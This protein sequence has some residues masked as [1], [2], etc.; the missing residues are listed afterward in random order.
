[1][2]FCILANNFCF[3][4]IT[5]NNSNVAA[6]LAN[7]LVGSGVT[8]S[9]ISLTCNTDGAGIFVSTNAMLGIDSGIVL[10]T[11][12]AKDSS[13]TVGVNNPATSFANEN[14]INNYTDSDLGANA[15]DICKLEFDFIP[16]GDSIKFQYK[17]GSE[18]YPDYV[19]S[20][21]N[22]IFGFYISGPG[23]AFP[24][25]LALVPGT[26]IPVTIN[27]INSGVSGIFGIFSNC[28]NM[29]AGSPFSAYYTNNITNTS[30]VYDGLTTLLESSALVTPCTTYHMKFVIA[31]IFD[32][33]YDSGVFLKAGSFK[34]EAVFFDS[35]YT[36][37]GLPVGWPYAT[38]GCNSDTIYIKRANV[39][40]NPQNVYVFTSGTATSGVDFIPIPSIVV[41]PANDSI[42]KIVVTPI[43]DFILDNNETLNIFI[44]SSGCAGGFSDTFNLVINE[45]PIITVS[46]S[47]T[48]CLGTNFTLSA[49]TA[50]LDTSM[51]F[52]WN[53]GNINQNSAIVSPLVNSSY[54]VTASYP[55][56][57]IFDSVV[58]IAVKPSDTATF[59]PILPICNGS[60]ISPLPTI[61][62]NGINGLWSPAINNISTT[63]YTFTP[64]S[65]ECAGTT[66]LTIIIKPNSTLT[67]SA[68][69][70]SNNLPYMWNGQSLTTSGTYTNTQLAANGCDSITTLNF[71]VKPTSTATVT[72]NA[73]SNTL[74]FVWNGQNLNFSG[75]Y[76]N[77]QLGS[78]GCDSIT[79]LNFIVKP[80]ST[81]TVTANACSNNLPFVWNGQNLNASGSFIHTQ[82]GSN[83]CDSTTTL[84]FIVKPTTTN[85]VTASACINNLPYLWN[86]QNLNTSGTFTNTQL[87]S[88]GCDSTT[89]MNF[90]VKPIATNTISIAVCTGDLPYS[91]NGQ[92]LNTAGTYTNTQLAVNGCDSI[93]TLNF[94][95]ITMTF[96]NIAANTCINNLP[97]LWNGQNINSSGIYTD[98]AASSNG[99]DS[100]TI[101]NFTVKPLLSATV[102]ASACSNNLPFVW[103]G[104]NLNTSGSYTNTQVGSNGCDSTTTLNFIVKPTTT[105]TITASACINNLPYVWNGQ[106]LN[107][108]GSYTN[109]QL[110]SNGCDSTTTLNFIVK[111]TTTAT[112]SATACSNNLPYAWNGQ[113]LNSSG[114]YTNTQLG[115]NGCDSTTTMNFVVKPTSSSSIFITVCPGD[116]PFSWNGQ[117]L[118]S[119]G[120]YTNTQ[121]GSNACDSVTTLNFSILT[122]TII[123]VTANACINSL[124]YTWNGQNILA[125]GIY[126]DTALSANGCDSVTI[127]NFTVKP[128]FTASVSANACVNNLPYIW[129]GQNLNS[130]G[131]YTFT[132]LG[133]NG[134]DSITTMNFTVIPLVTTNIIAS[135]CSNDLPYVWNG[136]IITA[137]GIYTHTQTGS[138]GC[139]SITNLTFT[140]IAPTIPLFNFPTSMC[141][142][143]SFGNLPSLSN[144]NIA[145]TWAPT[146]NNLATTTYT[147]T[148]NAGFCASPIN[149]TIVVTSPTALVTT[150]SNTTCGLVNGQVSIGAITGGT[151]P[152]MYNFNNQGFSTNLIY[153]N[154]NAGTYTIV[155]QDANNCSTNAVISIEAS[156]A[157]AD[158]SLTKVDA[159]CDL[160]NGELHISNIVGG[161]AP[162]T[163]TINNLNQ[164]SSL[165][166]FNMQDG[167]YVVEVTDAM[168]CKFSKTI[169]I[170][171]TPGVLDISTTVQVANCLNAD[172]SLQVTSVNGGIS[173]FVYSIVPR[174]ISNTTGNFQGINGNTN[175]TVTVTDVN[176]CTNTVTAFVGAIPCCKGAFIPSAFSPNGDGKN[177]IF[178]AHLP[179]N[180]ELKEFFINN[181]YG[182]QVFSTTEKGIGWIGVYNGRDADVAV[183]FYYLRYFCPT[184]NQEYILKGDVTLIR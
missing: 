164:S 130:T 23:F 7:K 160:S 157:V 135:S 52:T 129:N 19:C 131:V 84:N 177:D 181:R 6:D 170:F 16:Q 82:L 48:I 183:Y 156:S 147:F 31:D 17:F 5:I 108:S 11:G 18:E 163:I 65:G 124:P 38:E 21:F 70:C 151:S 138:N 97:Y 154:L 113:N 3:A 180:L 93:T 39:N 133:S 62:T 95:I 55:G 90:V 145:G 59:L 46:P 78:N 15:Q 98:T 50:I 111:P 67:I 104:Q 80:T 83:G 2:L 29:G 74:P 136:Q 92:T 155:V 69:A 4:Q 72:A 86:G 150:V 53:P 40:S 91:W 116:L 123:N 45:V 99:C 88:N 66:T 107:A 58:N 56:C 20:S 28:T 33:Q 128:L 184:D 87:G 43:Q 71:I 146:I 24:T 79:T 9:N 110:G 167:S 158:F 152:Y 117:N 42:V 34:S 37:V 10:T 176:N 1:M 119:A 102:N 175:Y 174:P 60:L 126:T 153:P 142:G 77:T 112:V 61:S 166:Y 25:N 162:Y 139:D 89:T 120:I 27:S 13:T 172:G 169:F 54:T 118:L 57:P 94:T 81:A 63:T 159:K 26:S 132:T 76:T 8:I 75:T 109:T 114:S 141:I 22:D 36:P 73:C 125:S 182:Q 30:V 12:Y 32:S 173:P 144:N 134:C 115:S 179:S 41:I 137:A 165:D 122:I 64:A 161:V 148:P 178:M 101:L 96:V 143:A 140:L 68:N 44:N 85:T 127:L 100:V 47:D 51:D 106:N 14:R 103:N 121:T 149:A 168:G 171:N 105:A 49:A 35:L